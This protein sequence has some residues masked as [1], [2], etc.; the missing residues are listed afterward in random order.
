MIVRH[1]C[2]TSEGLFYF[3]FFLPWAFSFDFFDFAGKKKK[4]KK[5]RMPPANGKSAVLSVICISVSYFLSGSAFVYCC[6]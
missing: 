2:S 1:Y 6:I 5:V 3:F 4:K